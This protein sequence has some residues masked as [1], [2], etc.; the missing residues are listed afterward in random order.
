MSPSPTVPERVLSRLPRRLLCWVYAKR[1]DSRLWRDATWLSFY[2]KEW[3]C[4]IR[5]SRRP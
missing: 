2:G 3:R 5:D 1:P 4:A